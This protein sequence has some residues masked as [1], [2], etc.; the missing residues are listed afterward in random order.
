MVTWPRS[1]SKMSQV[2]LFSLDRAHITNI[3]VRVDPGNA[4]FRWATNWWN[5]PEALARI[6]AL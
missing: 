5:Y 2:V 3:F 4:S 1:A 6:N